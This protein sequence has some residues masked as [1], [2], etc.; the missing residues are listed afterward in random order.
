M[1]IS[2]YYHHPHYHSQSLKPI[3]PQRRKLD[4]DVYKCIYIYTHLLLTIRKE[5]IRIDPVRHSAADDREPMKHHRRLV[6]LSRQQLRKN[7]KHDHERQKRGYPRNDQDPDGL[8]RTALAQ[9]L[10]NVR[11]KAH[12]R[13]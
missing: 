7:I 2:P 8:V 1:K 13:R 9:A 6:R 5:L 10:E 4:R 12:G 3:H 11:E